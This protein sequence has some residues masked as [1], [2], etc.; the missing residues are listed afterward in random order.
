MPKNFLITRPQHER[1]VTYLYNWSQE[2]LNFAK[3]NNIKFSDLKGKKANRNGVESYLTKQEPRFVIFNGHGSP[4]EVD[5]HQDE[6]LIIGGENE[7]LLKS[8]ITYTIA[9]D[10]A[11]E[12]GKKAVKNGCDSFIGY[13]GSF[14]FV[15]D[16]NRECNPVKDK[17]AE[18][19]KKTSNQIVFSILKGQTVKEAVEKSKRLSKKLIKEYS[20]SDAELSNKE[21]R[22][23][24]F[25]N[26]NLLK[27][28]GN[29]SAVF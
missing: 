3:D 16:S 24:L 20:T 27:L 12:L 23:W 29:E 11:T 17:L 25:W 28:L 5:G 22:F 18:P 14:C 10:S 26:M 6:P 8:K 9:C 15:H 21:I 1:T 4:N 7:K 19:F 2:I 13:E